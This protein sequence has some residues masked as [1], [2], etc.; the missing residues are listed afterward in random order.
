[1]GLATGPRASA[2]RPRQGRSSLAPG[3]LGSGV[4]LLKG[5][6]ASADDAALQ[7]VLQAES[8]SSGDAPRTGATANFRP[9]FP[10]AGG[11]LQWGRLQTLPI[12]SFPG[13]HSS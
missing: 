13:T 11:G 7:L 6:P 2:P 4:S 9:V 10:T 5:F 1:M 3:V 12:T 8:L